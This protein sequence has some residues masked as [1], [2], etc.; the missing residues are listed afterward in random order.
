MQTVGTPL[1][2]GIP[3]APG[4][5]PKYESNERFSCMITMTC[6]ILCIPWRVAA[7]VVPA[8]KVARP[9]ADAALRSLRTDRRCRV[10]RSDAIAGPRY[11]S[12]TRAAWGQY[13]RGI[14]GSD[15]GTH[16]DSGKCDYR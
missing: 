10:R 13:L 5:V 12:Q 6:L 14:R 9:S 2:M 7:G 4:N 11:R 16:R 1:R 3:T 8:G 15:G